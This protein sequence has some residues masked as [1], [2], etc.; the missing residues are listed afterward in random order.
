MKLKTSYKK[1]KG[2]THLNPALVKNRAGLGGFTLIELLTVIAIIG[3]LAGIVLMALGGARA[4][5]RDAKRKAEM[6]G[7]RYVLELHYLDNNQY[8]EITNWI[9]IEEDADTNGPFSQAMQPYFIEA[10]RDPLYP[11]VKDGKKFSYQYKSTPGGTACLIHAEL[12]G[13]VLMS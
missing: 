10:L 1:E 7:L 5:A 8:P 12:E 9:R 13:G 6:N 2:S 4:Q 3:I 11:E